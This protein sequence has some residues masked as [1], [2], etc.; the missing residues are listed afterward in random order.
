VQDYEKTHGLEY[1]FIVKLRTDCDTPARHGYSF[2]CLSYN[3]NAEFLKKPSDNTAFLDSDYQFGARREVFGRIASL[4]KRIKHDY[5]GRDLNY[6]NIDWGLISKCDVSAGK[7]KW[8]A[9][10]KDAMGNPPCFSSE[11]LSQNEQL[12]EWS[13]THSEEHTEWVTEKSFPSPGVSSEKI[14]ILDLLRSG[15]VIKHFRRLGKDADFDRSFESFETE[16]CIDDSIDGDCPAAM[17]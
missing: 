5:W 12:K 15:V 14:L 1:S 2:P 7:F 4:Y 3:V 9:Y 17:Y 13:H 10:P 8:L 6:F 11:C 16:D